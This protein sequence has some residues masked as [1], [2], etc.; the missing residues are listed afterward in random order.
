MANAILVSV[1]NI[2]TQSLTWMITF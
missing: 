1:T 2:Q